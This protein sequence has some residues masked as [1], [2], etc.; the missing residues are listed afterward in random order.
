MG[1]PGVTEVPSLKL[2]YEIRLPD[3]L[4]LRLRSLL[5]NWKGPNLKW[6][7][8]SHKYYTLA[9]RAIDN[10]PKSGLVLGLA[11]EV[12]MDQENER[13]ESYERKEERKERNDGRRQRKLDRVYYLDGKYQADRADG[14]ELPPDYEVSDSGSDISEYESDSDVVADTDPDSDEE[15]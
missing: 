6:N 8:F 5:A 1:I 4:L 15:K 13:E 11:H 7:P 14:R 10:Q 2:S 9:A 3:N 12:V